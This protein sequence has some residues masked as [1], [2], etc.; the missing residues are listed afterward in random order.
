S[1][2]NRLSFSFRL[3]MAPYDVIDYIVVHELAHI[4]IKNH[5]KRF[6]EYIGKVMPD[7]GRR[8]EWLAKKGYLLDI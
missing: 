1:S 2:D 6:W 5:S 3:V 7:Y 8:K 4:K